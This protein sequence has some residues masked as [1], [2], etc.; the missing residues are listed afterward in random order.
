[1]NQLT[2]ELLLNPSVRAEDENRL[3]RQARDILGLFRARAAVG[4]VVSTIDLAGIACQYNARLYEVRRYLVKHEGQCIDLV[5]KGEGGV[6][7]YKIV[8]CELSTFYKA[9]KERLD[10]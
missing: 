9:H 5:R 8:P 3:S 2:F 4:L 7:Y 1:V 10:T 6:N